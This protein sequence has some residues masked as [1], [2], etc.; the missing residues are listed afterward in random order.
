MSVRG[1]MHTEFLVPRLTGRGH[2]QV[3]GVHGRIML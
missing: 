1:G 2:V 3:V